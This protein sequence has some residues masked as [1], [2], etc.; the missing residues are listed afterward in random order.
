MNVWKQEW[1]ARD[2]GL[3]VT[4]DWWL[5]TTFGYH[6]DLYSAAHFVI[7]SGVKCRMFENVKA[8]QWELS[9]RIWR[10][11][12]PALPF[13]PIEPALRRFPCVPVRFPPHILYIYK[14]QG[15]WYNKVIHN[16]IWKP[17]K[18]VWKSHRKHLLIHRLIHLSTKIFN[19]RFL[20]CRQASSQSVRSETTPYSQ[21]FT[22][23]FT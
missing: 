23:S 21:L 14:R 18:N 7:L 20:R 15:K 2:W 11:S 22:K 17:Q 13:E 3:G 6:H 10:R 4:S 19:R 5:N 1:V 9:R 16:A 12:N 8:E